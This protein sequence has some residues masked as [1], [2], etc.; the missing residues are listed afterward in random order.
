MVL[1]SRLGAAGAAA[2]HGVTLRQ[3]LLP[4]LW[5]LLLP[6]AAPAPA[7]LWHEVM[8]PASSVIHPDQERSQRRVPDHG[9]RARIDLD[10]LALVEMQSQAI[11]DDRL[12]D[13][14][15]RADQVR[16]VIA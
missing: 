11:R 15:V 1:S 5:A 10:P 8:Y 12:H 2:Y 4:L 6:P 7:G 13:I 16:R 3:R 14:T 9:E